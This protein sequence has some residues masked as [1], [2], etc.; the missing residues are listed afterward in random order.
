M[1]S[2]SRTWFLPSTEYR[3]VAWYGIGWDI[4]QSIALALGTRPQKKTFPSSGCMKSIF[5]SLYFVSVR[6]P[7]MKPY[8]AVT[9]SE[10]RDLNRPPNR[11]ASRD[12][13]RTASTPTSANVSTFCGCRLLFPALV[14][15]IGL[16]FPS[17]YCFSYSLDQSLANFASRW[18]SPPN[19]QPSCFSPPPTGSSFTTTKTAAFLA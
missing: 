1:N 11:N 14:W 19:R 2:N 15:A 7:E 18:G 17:L 4:T 9:I 3:G 13:L 5:I 6:L 8:R 12:W 10:P 16:V